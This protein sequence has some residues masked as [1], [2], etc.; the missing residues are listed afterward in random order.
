M[1]F[2]VWRPFNEHKIDIYSFKYYN[3]FNNSFIS[4]VD[5]LFDG[6]LDYEI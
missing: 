3:I 6:K 1:F 4:S 2:Y 5:L